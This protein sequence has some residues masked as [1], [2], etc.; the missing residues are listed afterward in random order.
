MERCASGKKSCSC[1]TVK[2]TKCDKFWCPK[3][4]QLEAHMCPSPKQKVI[5][6]PAVVAP[7]MTY[8]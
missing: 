5:L 3:H 4:I 7:K 2:C 1:I 6:P 8:I